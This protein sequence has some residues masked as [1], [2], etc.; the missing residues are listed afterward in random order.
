MVELQWGPEGAWP[1]WKNWRHPRNI[2]FERPLKLQDDHPSARLLYRSL[3]Y[4]LFS[5][6]QFLW[7]AD[8]FF[9]D[10]F[11][12]FANVFVYWNCSSKTL[13]S[14]KCDFWGGPWDLKKMF[15]GSLSLAIFYG[16]LIN[17]TIIRPLLL[18]HPARKRMGSVLSTSDPTWRPGPGFYTG[19]VRVA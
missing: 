16:P 7:W 9:I 1:T 8:D 14:P 17:Y 19:K 10:A 6:I 12:Q 5:G 13:W 15:L 4:S 18:R 11:L 3:E 2:C